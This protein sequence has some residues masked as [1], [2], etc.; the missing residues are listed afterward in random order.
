M[1]SLSVVIF[2][3]TS[4]AQQNATPAA[5]L[6]SS[7]LAIYQIVLDSMF[8]AGAAGRLR[9]LVLRD[10]TRVL[11]GQDPARTLKNDFFGYPVDTAAVRDL[12]ARSREARS[13]KE[14]TRLPLRI[15]VTLVDRQTLSSLPQRDP[16]RYWSEFYEKYPGSDGL[17]EV[18]TI[19]YGPNGDFA[20]LLVDRGCGSL[21]GHGYIVALRRVAGV[22]RIASIQQ[23]WIS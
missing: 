10:S 8:V 11:D 7:D 19:G 4:C 21:C 23:T 1:H 18:S 15:P 9:Q 2:L 13:L 6:R 17:I 20:I 5:H 22:W 12:L 14:A 3:L 16:E